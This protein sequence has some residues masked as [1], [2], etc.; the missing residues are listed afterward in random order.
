MKLFS[1]VVELH[2]YCLLVL[3]HCRLWLKGRLFAIEEELKA[4]GKESTNIT[5]A[6]CPFPTETGEGDG[7]V[8]LTSINNTKSEVTTPTRP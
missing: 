4:A 6:H 7:K 1:V 2:I 3:Q 5:E 8:V